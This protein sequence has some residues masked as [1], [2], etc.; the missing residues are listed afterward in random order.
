[1]KAEM[2]QRRII[3]QGLQRAK[4]SLEAS[5][6]QLRE[7]EKLRDE[8]TH[9]IVHDLRTPLSAIITGIQ[10]ARMLGP[11]DKEQEESLDLAVQGGHTLLGMIND[12]LDISKMENGSL[13]LK[14]EQLAARQLVNYVIPQAAVLAGMKNLD[15]RVE[16]AADLPPISG[17]AEKL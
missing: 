4:E 16:L 5:Y 17:D 7:L 14:R 3:Q 12:L 8:L 11:L 15:L 2:G 10:T 13:Q 1:L 6:V 9:M